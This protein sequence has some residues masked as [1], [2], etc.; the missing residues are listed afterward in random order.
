VTR[1][2]SKRKKLTRA[3]KLEA[4]ARIVVDGAGLRTY[5]LCSM[6]MR[7]AGCT[8]RTAL[9]Y[10]SRAREALAA[11]LDD[12]LTDLVNALPTA[13]RDALERAK[14][15]GDIKAEARLL[16]GIANLVGSVPRQLS[17]DAT[18]Q[19]IEFTVVNPDDVRAG[20]A[21]RSA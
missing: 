4:A 15:K 12:R 8:R 6:F 21:A 18:P 17:E 7:V 9:R 2:S 13:Y 14:L 3:E 5:A 16:A 11:Q 10:L 20:L 1:K 19:F